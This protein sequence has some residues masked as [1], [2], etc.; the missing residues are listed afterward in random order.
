[1]RY[2][3]AVVDWWRDDRRREVQVLTD[4]GVHKAA[5]MAGASFGDL[6]PRTPLRTIVLLWEREPEEAPDGVAVVEPEDIRDLMELR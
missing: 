5:W 3:F 1:M 2:R 4:G 6:H